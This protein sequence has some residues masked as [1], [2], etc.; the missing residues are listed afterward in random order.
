MNACPN[1][2]THILLALRSL[3]GGNSNTHQDGD[4]D[5]FSSDLS[6]EELQSRLGHMAFVPTAAFLSGA[7]EYVPPGGVRSPPERFADWFRR[8]LS[9]P[10]PAEEMERCL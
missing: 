4:D 5:M 8:A 3:T 7:D 2:H 6:V 9:D 1:Q 10:G